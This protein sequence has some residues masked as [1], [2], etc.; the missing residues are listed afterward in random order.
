MLLR[1]E[2]RMRHILLVE[3]DKALARSYA[4]LLRKQFAV[5]AAHTLADALE[6]LLRGPRPLHAVWSDRWLEEHAEDGIRVLCSAAELHP[7]AVLVMVTG[8]P[9]PRPPEL[10][11]RVRVFDKSES[12]EAAEFLRRSLGVT[13]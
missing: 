1:A 8:T 5:H 6:V 7:D 3:D 12:S 2:T 13:Y 11:L 10:P 4:R 9:E